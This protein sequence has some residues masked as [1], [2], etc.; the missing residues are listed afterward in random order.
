MKRP[1]LYCLFLMVVLLSLFYGCDDDESSGENMMKIYLG[2]PENEYLLTNEDELTLRVRDS[3]ILVIRGGIPVEGSSR[4]DYIVIVSQKLTVKSAE[5][6][7][8]G[9]LIIANEAGSSKIAVEDDSSQGLA[10]INVNVVNIKKAYNVTDTYT[11]IDVEDETLREQMEAEVNERF[12]PYSTYVMEY[13][14]YD[15]P[16]GGL[17][18]IEIPKIYTPADTIDGTFKEVTV[19][20]YTHFILQYD[21]QTVDFKFESDPEE[22]RQ[23]YLIED[24]TGKYQKKYPDKVVNK[25]HAVNAVWIVSKS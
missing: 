18:A 16:K 6:Y 21:D 12:F 8:N 7:E 10:I 25:V 15:E 23:G 14:N 20:G 24:L 4:G 1:D 2:N 13:M 19:S 17:L 3:L 11:D 22:K 9:Y 5:G